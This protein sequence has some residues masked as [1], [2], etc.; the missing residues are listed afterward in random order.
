LAL[1][2]HPDM[3]FL[4]TQMHVFI[5]CITIFELLMLFFQIIYYQERPGDP[6]RLRYLILL[7]L[8]IAYNLGS[9]GMMPDERIPI[10]MMAQNIL[11]YF[12]GFAASM[13]AIFFY[14]KLFDLQHLKFLAT[15]GL[16]WFLFMSFLG[17]VASYLITED[18]VLSRKITMVVPIGYGIVFVARATRSLLLK[19]K[20]SKQQD[21]ITDT[22][23]LAITAYFSM[24]CWATLPIINFL[25]DFQV[26]EH[27]VTNA[28]FLLMSIFYIRSST[29]QAKEEAKKLKALETGLN[30]TVQEKT[31][32][33]EQLSDSQKEI[34]IRLV[35]EAYVSVLAKPGAGTPAVPTPIS[36]LSQLYESSFKKYNLSRREIEV[37]P[38]LVKGSPYKVI[39][40]ELNISEKTVSKHISNIFAKTGVQ[41]KGELINMLMLATWQPIS[42]G[43]RD[44]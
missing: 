28:G 23:Y 11:A 1:N 9:G 37:L 10:P 18:L 16:F 25:G 40:E 20:E 44:L 8:L 19:I 41:N 29:Q 22:L 34:F 3:M 26:L 27:S 6:R 2:N 33:I 12:L 21:V 30:G 32:P 43:H 4:G 35:A 36:P 39:A 24:M 13:Y 38:L 14:Y 15:S 7:V 42:P 31:N 17:F 5:F